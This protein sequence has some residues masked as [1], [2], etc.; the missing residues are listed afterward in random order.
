[1]SRSSRVLLVALVVGI[2]NA[3]VNG[4]GAGSNEG[5]S[6]GLGAALIGGLSTAVAFGIAHGLELLLRGK[7][8]EPSRVRIRL[9]PD[10]PPLPGRSRRRLL[11]GV[12]GGVAGGIVL[13]LTGGLGSEII[14]GLGTGI[15]GGLGVGVAFGLVCGLVGALMVRFEAPID[16]TSTA[17]P[18]DLLS[19]NRTTVAFQTLLWG[20]VFGLCVAL[21]GGVASGLA[22]GLVVGLGV[23][24]G[25]GLSITAWGQWMV[26]CRIWL[27]L[28]G[29]LPWAVI[30]FMDDA[31]RRGVL[32]RAGAVYQFRHARL[33]DHLG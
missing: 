23:G 29:R 26:L 19:V 1:M 7:A 3:L 30:A 27:P 8:F 13:G 18:A 20:P 33:Q 2:L 22:F 5:I 16:V 11:L 28:T 12:A 25:C 31:C 32:R 21:V 24:V 14:G 4:L 10:T 17:S 6:A 15:V 9:H